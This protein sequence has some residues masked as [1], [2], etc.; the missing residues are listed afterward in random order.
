MGDARGR[1]RGCI[2]E[3]LRIILR[4]PEIVAATWRAARQHSETVT[5]G[6]VREALQ[7]FDPLWNELFP[8]EQARIVQLLVEGVDVRPEG[9]AIR[10]QAEGLGH[11]YRELSGATELGSAA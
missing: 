9:L 4:S 8:A 5:E 1:D 3:Q 6:E 11:L 10:L 7:Q 2:I